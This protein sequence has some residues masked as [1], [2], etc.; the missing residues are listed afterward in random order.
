MKFDMLKSCDEIFAFCHNSFKFA[1]AA[2]CRFKVT[3][4]AMCRFKFAVLNVGDL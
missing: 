1:V 3:V 2:M 4:A